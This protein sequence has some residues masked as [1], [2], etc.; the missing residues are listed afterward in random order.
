VTAGAKGD[1]TGSQASIQPANG[2]NSKEEKGPGGQ[3]PTPSSSVNNSLNSLG[4][5][6]GAA[7]PSPEQ[8][9]GRRTEQV[10][11]LPVSPL[12]QLSCA[13]IQLCRTS[14]YDARERI[15]ADAPLA[16]QWD[17]PGRSINDPKSE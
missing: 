5:N 6:N 14:F 1:T 15:D 10:S 9:G 2:R 16:A 8:L 11:D 4:G 3:T 13:R 7:T 17:C 12:F